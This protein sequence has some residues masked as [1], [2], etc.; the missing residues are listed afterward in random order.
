MITTHNMKK[1]AGVVLLSGGLGLAALGTGAGT[2]QAD[3]GPFYW[4]PG[5]SIPCSTHSQLR[6]RVA[7][8]GRGLITTGT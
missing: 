5:D 2:A 1:M 7:R 8:R 4:C 3:S 6:D